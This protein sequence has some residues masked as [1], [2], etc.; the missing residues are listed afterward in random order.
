MK[1]SLEAPKEGLHFLTLS[2]EPSCGEAA[3]VD[4]TSWWA[5]SNS[6][7]AGFLIHSFSVTLYPAFPA[8]SLSC[9]ILLWETSLFRSPQGRY[10][11]QDGGSP[12]VHI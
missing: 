3:S 11:C 5:L 12:G 7:L 6:S 1:R 8:G 2:L 9:K 10:P 4:L